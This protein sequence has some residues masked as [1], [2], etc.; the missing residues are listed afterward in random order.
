MADEK[1]KET[2]AQYDIRYA[3]EKLKRIPLDVKK[4]EYDEIKAAADHVCASCDDGG[5]G[6]YPRALLDA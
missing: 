5:P 6:L 1:R 4:E 3:K 2:K